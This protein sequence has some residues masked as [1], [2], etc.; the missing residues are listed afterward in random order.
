M[1]PVWTGEVVMQGLKCVS[2]VLHLE[3]SQEHLLCV[4][5]AHVRVGGGRDGVRGFKSLTREF[6][7]I[8]H[9]FEKS[10]II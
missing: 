1:Y 6:K 5:E 9:Y 3:V 10:T 7:R 8:F 4:G 2:T